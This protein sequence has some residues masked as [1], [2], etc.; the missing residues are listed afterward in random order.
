MARWSQ[1]QGKRIE[2]SEVEEFLKDL[3]EVYKKHG[4]SLAHE[5]TQGGFIVEKFNEENV[6]WL[7]Q[8]SVGESLEE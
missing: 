8:A 2:N 7:M 6:E 4:F 1:K 5:D 3:I